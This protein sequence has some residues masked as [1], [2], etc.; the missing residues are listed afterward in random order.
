MKEYFTIGKIVRPHGVK[1]AVRAETYTSNPNR[2]KKLKDVVIDSKTF[3]VE[4]ISIDSSNFMLIKLKGIDTMDDA[5]KLRN[6]NVVIKR[7]QLPE[8]ENGTYY[9]DDLIGSDVLVDGDKIGILSKIEQF[10]SADV[11]EVAL[12]EGGTVNFPA[13]K[14]VFYK[15]DV[16]NGVID[17]KGFIF[18]RIC[19]Y[20]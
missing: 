20:N 12:N 16:K 19:V 2:F 17:L 6:K 18:S 14:D 3:D 1:G 11:Y 5:E 9:I 4:S 7:S 13:L 8:P 15:V 10:G